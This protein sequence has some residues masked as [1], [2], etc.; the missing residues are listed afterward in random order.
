MS[1]FWCTV[2]I[3]LV[4]A[5]CAFLVHGCLSFVEGRRA[6]PSSHSTQTR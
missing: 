6:G 3:A 4:L 2:R 1:E 5:F